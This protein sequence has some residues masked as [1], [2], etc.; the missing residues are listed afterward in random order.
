MT[1]KNKINQLTPF[2]NAVISFLLIISAAATVFPVLLVVAISFSSAD[3]ISQNGYSLMPS[4]W[5]LTAYKSV[6]A[7]GKQILDSYIVT[8]AHTCV[9]TALSLF[10]QSMFAFAL[11]Q[12]RFKAGKVFTFITFFTMLFSGGLVPSYVIN[13]RYLNLYDTFWI[14]VLPG[15]V[16]AYNVI[17]LRTFIRTTIPDSMMEAAIVDGAND[18]RVYA[19]IVMPLFKP[20]LATI[21]LFSVVG[22]WNDWFTGML[23]IEN[24]KLIPLQTMLTRIQASIDFIKQSAMQGTP[25]SAQMQETLKDMPTESARMAITIIATLPIMFIYP[26]FQKYFIKGLTLGSVKG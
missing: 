2:W 16:T 3:S 5:S 26:F 1:S 25:G 13:V 15:L 23:Y 7:A 12:K 19:T 21:A 6:F 11:A 10:I 22:R 18:F 4:G 20:A 8:I 17:I 24:P 9:G 14:L